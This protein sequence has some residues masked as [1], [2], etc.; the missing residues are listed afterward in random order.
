MINWTDDLRQHSLKYIDDL[1]VLGREAVHQYYIPL[2]LWHRLDAGRFEFSDITLKES[3]R[4]SSRDVDHLVSVK[5][6]ETLTKS[7]NAAPGQQSGIPD[8]DDLSSKSNAL[9]NCCLLEKTFNISKGSDPLRV[10]IERVHE[11]DINTHTNP[12]DI[13][14]LARNIGFDQNLLDATGRTV[15]EVCISVDKR[16]TEMKKGLNEYIMDA[17]QRVDL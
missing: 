2:W 1:G 14:D 10:F 11:F 8:S 3:K 5:F 17:R 9:G 16:T 6:W 13:D 12:I 7:P 15:E 4:G